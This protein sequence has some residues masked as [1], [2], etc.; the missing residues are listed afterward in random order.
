MSA[1]RGFADQYLLPSLR[2]GASEV[3]RYQGRLGHHR[4]AAGAVARKP[5]GL[6]SHLGPRLGGRAGCRHRHA[7]IRPLRRSPGTDRPGRLRSVPGPPDRRVGPRSS[8]RRRPGRRHGRGALPRRE[9][10]RA[11]HELDRSAAAQSA[12]RS[13]RAA[14]SRTSSRRRVW[15]S[16]AGWTPGPTSATRSS[17][18]PRATA[19]PTSTRTMS[20]PTTSGASRSRPGSCGT[21]PSRTRCCATCC[22][23]SPRRPRSWPGATMTSCRGRTTSTSHDLLPNSEIHPLDAGHFAWEQAAGGIRPPR[24][25]LG[26]R[27]IS[28]RRSGLRRARPRS[29]PHCGQTC[30]WRS[31]DHDLCLASDESSSAGRSP[32]RKPVAAHRRRTSAG[33]GIDCGPQTA[34]IAVGA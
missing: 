21:T 5:L 10:A 16:C 6:P 3:R 23:R 8:A 1:E 2:R 14:R 11:R 7:G 33:R 12:S 24:R 25:R 27:R 30:W 13:R 29:A 31:P 26:Q 18:L 17:R 32:P 9:V 22:R 28:A 15:T 34:E 20:A 4:S 19:S